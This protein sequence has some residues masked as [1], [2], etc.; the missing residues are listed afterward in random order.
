MFDS[1][2]G[3]YTFQE[4]D[5]ELK[6]ALGVTNRLLSLRSS[7][8]DPNEKLKYS[9]E[10]FAYDF[11]FD[12]GEIKPKIVSA[13]NVYPTLDCFE[14]NFS[15]LKNRAATVSNPKYKAKYNHILWASQEKHRDYATS[16]IEGYYALLVNG[17]FSSSDAMEANAF[18]YHFKNLF[19]LSQTIGHKKEETLDLLDSVLGTDRVSGFEEYRLIKFLVDNGKIARPKLQR[20]SEYVKNASERE[21]FERCRQHFLELMIL[22]S[23]KLGQKTSQYHERLGEYFLGEAHK[24]SKSFIVHDFYLNALKAFQKSGNREKIESTTV[25]L[26]KAKSTIDFKT[27]KFEV[28]D[29]RLQAYWTAIESH[30]DS[31]INKQDE[32]LLY[33]YLTYGEQ[34]LPKAELLNEKN[35]SQVFDLFSV[36]NFDINKNVTGSKEGGVNSYFIHLQNFT[37]NHLWMVFSRGFR[38]GKMSFN[39]FMEFLKNH[40]WYGQDF[41][42][43]NAQGESEG[44]DW[45]DLLRPSLASFFDQSEID[46]KRNNES[47][48]G[49]I[50]SI[51]SLALK[52]EGLLR[53]FSRM[54]EAQTIEI[55]ENGTEERISFEKLLENEKLKELMPEDNLAFFKF[56]FTS[57]GMNLRNNVAHCFYPA[58]KYSAGGMFLL[59]TALLRLGAYKFNRI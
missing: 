44:F 43:L 59:L 6:F 41:T 31:L 19:I 54:I 11:T 13:G 50:L 36:M 53:E 35:R 18:E 17:K 55:K 38:S 34:I 15:Y 27:V 2:Q 24:H 56:L 49:Y 57:E 30:I 32:N 3:Y 1:L 40:T 20:L 42:Y 51:D 58:R 8:V 10:I 25:L 9:H 22:L 29:E 48:A 7:E 28:T 46:I 33:L 14:N 5:H 52:F 47:K 26:Q 23:Q 16:A 21:D 4:N 12:L 37:S 39:G 45:L